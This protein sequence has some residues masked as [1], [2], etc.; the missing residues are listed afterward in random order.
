MKIEETPQGDR[1]V[2][3]LQGR[4]TIA[5]TEELRDK[6]DELVRGGRVQIALDV[7]GVPYMDSAGLGE[8]TRLYLT[9]SRANGQLKLINVPKK[10]GE[11]LDVT[12]LREILEDRS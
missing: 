9:V 11:L 3:K 5:E 10:V 4:L 12:R 6:I 2:L 1:T 8:V 7:A